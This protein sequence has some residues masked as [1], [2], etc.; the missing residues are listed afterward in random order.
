[1]AFICVRLSDES[2]AI[3]LESGAKPASDIG[4]GWA[5]FQLFRPDYP[6]P[7]LRFWILRAYATARAGSD[8]LVA[9]ASAATPDLLPCDQCSEPTACRC[10]MPGC[11][12]AVCGK[13]A[14]VHYHLDDAHD[15]RMLG[16]ED[17]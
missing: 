17:W 10:S 6:E 1:M 8:R 4:A 15:G 3:A 9:P 5:R 12:D 2:V 14:C 13:P 16:D 11:T 7:D